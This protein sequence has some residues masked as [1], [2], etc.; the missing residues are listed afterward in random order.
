MSDGMVNDSFKTDESNAYTILYLGQRK[1]GKTTLI[2]R[3]F[4]QLPENHVNL[5]Q[6]S[7]DVKVINVQSFKNIKIIDIPGSRDF[8]HEIDV[9]DWSRSVEAGG[10]DLD[11]VALSKCPKCPDDNRTGRNNCDSTIGVIFVIDAQ[12][13]Y[14]YENNMH[15]AMDAMVDAA[16][17]TSLCFR[18]SLKF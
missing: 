2:Q 4:E 15:S 10:L 8:L 17:K 14:T 3:V 5:V 9:S 6:P 13:S 1:S 18:K 12:D 11:T 16:K 7:I